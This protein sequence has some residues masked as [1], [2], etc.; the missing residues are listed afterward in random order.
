MLQTALDGLARRKAPQLEEADPVVRANL[1]VIR[2]IGERQCKQALLLEIGLVDTR[3]TARHDSRSAEVSGTQRSVFPATSLTVVGIT[4]DDP[5][6]FR[7][8]IGA[9]GGGYRLSLPTRKDVQGCSNFV[10]VGVHRA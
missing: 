7:R 3:K 9:S 10:R 5:R 1:V 8:S 2:G 4:H 6:N